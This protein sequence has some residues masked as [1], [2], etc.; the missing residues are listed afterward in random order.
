M[1]ACTGE[2][3]TKRIEV[4]PLKVLHG[5]GLENRMCQPLFILLTLFRAIVDFQEGAQN[6]R[7]YLC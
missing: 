7:A 5:R 6:K 4:F 1:K 3:A 2:F